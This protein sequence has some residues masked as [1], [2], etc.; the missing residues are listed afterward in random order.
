MTQ[1]FRRSALLG[2]T[3]GRSP[4]RRRSP[5]RPGLP[6]RSESSYRRAPSTPPDIIS[7]LVA[8]EIT[9]SEGWRMVVE[10][11]PGAMQTIGG[12]EVLKQPADGYTVCAVALPA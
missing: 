4:L 10:N 11:K 8:N 9:Q 2:I 3:P 6:A 5:R 1:L 12:A 7:R